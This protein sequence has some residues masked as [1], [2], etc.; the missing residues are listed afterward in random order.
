MQATG[1]TR[2]TACKMVHF[3]ENTSGLA[4]KVRGHEKSYERTHDGR[5]RKDVR[6]STNKRDAYP[7]IVITLNPRNQA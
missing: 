5:K 4:T 3:C 6:N 7:L 2:V 1:I